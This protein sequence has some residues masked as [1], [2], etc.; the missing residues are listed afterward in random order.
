MGFIASQL[1]PPLHHSTAASAVVVNVRTLEKRGRESG[2]FFICFENDTWNKFE[3]GS[4]GRGPGKVAA[5]LG[6]HDERR[7]MTH[8]DVLD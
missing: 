3:F 6:G 4:S 8:A 2:K 5:P 1:G 7:R